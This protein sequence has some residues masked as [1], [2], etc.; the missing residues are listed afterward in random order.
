MSDVTVGAPLRLTFSTRVGAILTDASTVTLNIRKPDGT[1]ETPVTLG[2]VI[3]DA[4]GTYHYDY[5][6]A[7]A[8][9]YDAYWVS[10]GPASAALTYVFDVAGAYETSLATL[11]EMKAY[12]NKS[13]ALTVDDAELRSFLDA[14]SDVITSMTGITGGP[15]TYTFPIGTG[16][17]TGSSAFALGTQAQYMFPEGSIAS[18]IS[19]VDSNNVVLDPALYAVNIHAGVLTFLPGATPL[20]AITVTYNATDGVPAP[21]RIA[22]LD[23]CADLW[24]TQKGA[25]SGSAYASRISTRLPPAQIENLAGPAPRWQKLIAPYLLVGTFA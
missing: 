25:A 3:R 10:T 20:T 12:L 13:E 4:A 21:V 2:A 8:G 19:V 16:A 17:F 5:T 18:L 22:T 14:A 23:Y 1:N 9:H 11:D 24:R 6:P 7:V 15:K